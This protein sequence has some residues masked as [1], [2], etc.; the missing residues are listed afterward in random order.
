MRVYI[1]THIH[2]ENA[3]TNDLV[4]W[5]KNVGKRRKEDLVKHLYSNKKICTQIYVELY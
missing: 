3:N 4:F 5:G 1:Y 2:V